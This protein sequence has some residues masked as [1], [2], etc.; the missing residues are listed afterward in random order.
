M[1]QSA[2]QVGGKEKERKKGEE[3]RESKKLDDAVCE[4]GRKH[5]GKVFTCTVMARTCLRR[6]G[7]GGA[8]REGAGVQACICGHGRV[9]VENGSD[10]QT[11]K[12]ADEMRQTQGGGQ[13]PRSSLA[14]AS[15]QVR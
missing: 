14:V 2:V 11:T 15:R 4:L 8:C 13:I 10:E 12:I 1:Q 3:E 5:R 6:A 9:E 7:G